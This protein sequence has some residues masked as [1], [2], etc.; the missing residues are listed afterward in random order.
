MKNYGNGLQTNLR[1][2]GK[3]K[4][5]SSL[6]LFS[7]QIPSRSWRRNGSKLSLSNTVSIN[8]VCQ[9]YVLSKHSKSPGREPVHNGW[10]RVAREGC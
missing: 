9:Y 10:S 4:I 6:L 5:A 2:N 8:S 7:N 3:R 1:P